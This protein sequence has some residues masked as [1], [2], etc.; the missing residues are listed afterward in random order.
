LSNPVGEIDK[1]EAL[2]AGAAVVADGRDINNALAYPGIFRGA[3]D[4]RAPDITPQ[5]ELAAAKALADLTPPG[6]LLPEILDKNV[7]RK[8]ARA[9]MDASRA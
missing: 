6:E 3:L 2:A 5:M 7:H 1:E 9:V 8:V 4:A